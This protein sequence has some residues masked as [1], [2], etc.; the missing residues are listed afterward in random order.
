M[1][2]AYCLE[3]GELET[4]DG[5]VIHPERAKI[6]LEIL[7]NGFYPTPSYKK[8]EIENHLE[9]NRHMNQMI[10]NMESNL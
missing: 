4:K 8:E 5:R 7:E 6:D 1:D 9:H 2:K 10:N 3:C